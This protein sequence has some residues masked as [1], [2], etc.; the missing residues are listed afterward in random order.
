MCHYFFR[1]L[2]LYCKSIIVKNFKRVFKSTP[3]SLIGMNAEL[4]EVKSGNDYKKHNALDRIRSVEGWHFGSSTVFCKGNLQSGD[5]RYLPWY[6]IM[7]YRQNDAVREMKY[8]IDL[9]G[10]DRG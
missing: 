4:I 7:F 2:H 5:I 3:V 1:L 8:E 9:S 6:M 10:L